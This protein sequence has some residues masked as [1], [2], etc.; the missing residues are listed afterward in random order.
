ME[1]KTMANNPANNPLFKHFRQPSVYLKLPSQGQYYPEGAIDLPATGQIPIYPMTVKDELTLKTPDA[2]MNGQ[3]MADVIASCCPNIKDV[4]KT[5]V[6]D[7]DPI[8][9]A[10]RIASYGADMDIKTDCPHCKEENE[11]TINLNHILDN[12]KVIDYSRPAFIDGLKF[13]FKPQTYKN[14]NDVSLVNYEEQR[15]IDSVINNE[16]LSDEVKAAKFAESF[17]RLKKLNIDTIVVCIE[18][19]TITDNEEE[20]V[21][22]EAKNIAEFLEN[23]SREVYNEIKERVNTLINDNKTK[24]MKLSCSSCTKEYDNSLEFNQSNFFGL[25]F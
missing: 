17:N 3:G 12:A 21:V 2:L 19:I 25:D 4:W 9:I 13:K 1:I 18:S 11:H 15:L 14:I 7:V 5:P 22:T 23:C 6:V 16:S 8:F 20:T 24:P 10:I